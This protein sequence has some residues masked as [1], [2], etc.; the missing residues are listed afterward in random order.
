MLN[1]GV[2]NDSYVPLYITADG[3]RSRISG[4]ETRTVL[5]C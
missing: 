5:Q 3:I 2:V 1:T 4:V